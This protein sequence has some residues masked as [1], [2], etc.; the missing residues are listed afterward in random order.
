MSEREDGFPPYFSKSVEAVLM[1]FDR[2]LTSGQ[3]TRINLRKAGM[4]MLQ[5]ADMPDFFPEPQAA[6]EFENEEDLDDE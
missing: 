2:G 5:F 1:V 3:E 4:D 6:E